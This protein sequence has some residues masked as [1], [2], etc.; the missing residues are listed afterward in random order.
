MEGVTQVSSKGL[1]PQ[2]VDV[3]RAL[4]DSQ[5]LLAQRVR[6]A[7]HEHEGGHCP[8]VA[9]ALPGPTLDPSRQTHTIVATNPTRAGMQGER[10]PEHP[11]QETAP[12]A[13]DTAA[14]TSH[15]DVGAATVAADR[16]EGCVSASLT[17]EATT[18]FN[19][20]LDAR[21]RATSLPPPWP[22]PTGPEVP[23]RSAATRDYNFF[24]ELDDKL[25]VLAGPELRDDEGEAPDESAV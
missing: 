8:A 17:I 16:P 6:R 2:L 7:C 12:R 23:G 9:G 5:T 11:V 21:A 22:E 20:D 3:L 19:D 10:L 25:A 14:A 24:D 13:F 15:P 18:A 1:L 4:T